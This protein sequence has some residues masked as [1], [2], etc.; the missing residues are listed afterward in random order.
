MHKSRMWPNIPNSSRSKKNANNTVVAPPNLNFITAIQKGVDRRTPYG[1]GAPDEDMRTFKD[2][3]AFGKITK[4]W[5]FLMCGYKRGMYQW[6]QVCVHVA[7]THDY[8]SRTPNARWGIA[9]RGQYQNH[10]TNIRPMNI[11]SYMAAEIANGRIHLHI[12]QMKG[13]SVNTWR[14]GYFRKRFVNEKGITT[15][16]GKM[17]PATKNET[18]YANTPLQLPATVQTSK[19]I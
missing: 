16:L 10:V 9:R 11:Q 8:E 19:R 1:F 7:A 6:Y 3:V 2:N 5:I 15:H 4:Q 18:Q 13:R 14:C 12:E 17:R